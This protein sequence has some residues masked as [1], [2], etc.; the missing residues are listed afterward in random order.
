MRQMMTMTADTKAALDAALVAYHQD[1]RVTLGLKNLRGAHATLP[2][3]VAVWP[4]DKDGFFRLSL[5]EN[6]FLIAWR[7][8]AIA[9]IVAGRGKLE[10][11]ASYAAPLGIAL[12]PAIEYVGKL[13]A[14]RGIGAVRGGCFTE[15]VAWVRDDSVRQ[16][17]KYQQRTRPTILFLQ[18]TLQIEAAGMLAPADDAALAT[19]GA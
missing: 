11:A 1:P 18:P 4:A 17:T 16:P 2:P 10:D 7:C 13:L 5:T 9:E 3:V 14:P 15:A 19:I 12:E 6:E 8:Y